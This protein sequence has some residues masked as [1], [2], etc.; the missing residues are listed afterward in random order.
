VSSERTRESRRSPFALLLVLAVAWLG[1]ETTGPARAPG[2]PAGAAVAPLP[3]VPLGSP[4]PPAPALESIVFAEDFEGMFPGPW[5]SE[6]TN[7][8][9]GLDHWN[10]TTFKALS[11]ARSAWAAQDGEHNGSQNS[12][13]HEYDKEMRAYL[14][15]GVDLNPYLSARIE[16]SYWLDSEPLFDYLRVVYYTDTWKEPFEQADQLGTWLSASV[17]IPVS[18]TRVGFLFFSDSS[19]VFEGV[20][21]DDVTMIGSDVPG[22]FDCTASAAATTGAETDP[23]A[24]LG[25]VFGGTPP[26]SWLWDFGDGTTS[27]AEDP[28][29]PYE[30]GN[31]TVALTVADSASQTCTRVLPTIEVSHAGP[32]TV[33]VAPASVTANA[34][35]NVTFR[36]TVT[37]ALEHEV[38]NASAFAWT[39]QT[40]GCGTPASVVGEAFTFRAP[41]GTAGR[42]CTIFVSASSPFG[43]DTQTVTVTIPA[44][45]NSIG[46][47]ALVALVAAI[48]GF[49]FLLAVL[50][51]RQA[52][53]PV[54]EIGAA[55]PESPEAREAPSVPVE[56]RVT[57]AVAPA[58]SQPVTPFCPRCGRPVLYVWEYQ[59]WYCP[60]EQVYPWG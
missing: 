52:A 46:L 45:P 54:E 25:E 15:R 3:D 34:G 21:I 20:Y 6:D 50:Q 4:E 11:G 60:G 57:P 23:F 8:R 41:E 26:Y 17:P 40:E 35:E 1:T 36:A 29:H 32:V 39:V 31:Y 42:S 30:A 18:A 10:T 16:F 2:L 19:V 38:T 49:L 44:P 56:P 53:R 47:V 7:L 13:S 58:A 22:P 9:E 27:T 33:T 12:V 37:D 24:F 14:H 5:I 55:A 43:S 51:R 48:I 28:T 59:R